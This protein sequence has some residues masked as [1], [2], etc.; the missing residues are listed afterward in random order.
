MPTWLLGDKRY[1]RVVQEIADYVLS[2]MTDESGGFHSTEDADSE[3]EEGKFYVWTVK[4]IKEILGE[5]HGERFCYVYDVEPGGNFEGSSILNLPKSIEQCAKLRQWDLPS[6]TEE[7]KQS[8]EKL[9][10]VRD[11]RIRPAKDD[12]ILVSWNALMINALAAPPL[13]WTVLNISTPP[14]ALPSSSWITSR[15]PTGVC[16]TAGGMARQ[17]WMP[18]W[19]TTRT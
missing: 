10:A 3:G 15:V 17:N 18:T 4:E 16:C 9:L 14:V 19:M 13:S 12:K 2:Y 6:L 7:L 8:R 1:A 5:D 11:Q